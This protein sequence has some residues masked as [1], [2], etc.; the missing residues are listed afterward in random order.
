[1]KGKETKRETE[2]GKRALKGG[3]ATNKWRGYAGIKEV[4]EK[5]M[6]G[7]SNGKRQRHSR[8]Q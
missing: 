5:K 6:K 7:K 2:E 3:S 4:T 8:C 1:M